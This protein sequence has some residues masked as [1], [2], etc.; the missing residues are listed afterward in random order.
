MSNVRLDLSGIE[1]MMAAISTKKKVR[2]GVLGDKNQRD[3]DEEGIGN[4]GIGLVHEF[5]SATRNIPA[6]SFLRMPLE[7]KAADLGQFI[8]NEILSLINGNVSED[9][10]LKRIGIKAEKIIQGAFQS[11]GY[12]QWKALKEST[13]ASKGSSRPLIDTGELRKSITS[14]VVDG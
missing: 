12:G 9:Q 13:I 5:G 6:R 8:G 7:T 11:G 10:S 2:V 3:D 14:E 1:K 4:A